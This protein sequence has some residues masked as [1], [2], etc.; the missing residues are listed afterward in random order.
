[1]SVN[2]AAEQFIAPDFPDL[3]ART[4]AETGL[5]TDRLDLEVTE[6]SFIDNFDAAAANMARIASSGTTFSLDDFGSG[7]SSLAHLKRLPLSTLK[8][9]RAFV[10]DIVS[11]PSD[12]TIARGVS[13]M[14]RGLGLSVVAEGV[15]TL[16]Q[17]RVVRV[18]RETGSD[19]IQGY[20][21]DRPLEC[22]DFEERMKARHRYR[23]S[24]A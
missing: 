1:M 19:A 6:T 17:L 10:T 3:V 8:L 7:Y 23:G 12:R 16:E 11:D 18:V 5:P 2:P 4:L 20:L 9:D 24:G 15:E 13:G 21:F 14:A 22:A